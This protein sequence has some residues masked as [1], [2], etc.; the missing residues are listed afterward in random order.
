MKEIVDNILKNKEWIFSGIGVLLVIAF[1]KLLQRFFK[2]RDAHVEPGQYQATQVGATAYQ[3]GRDIII[4]R[5]QVG[6]VRSVRVRVHRAF[7][8]DDPNVVWHYFINVVNT[9]D[10]S[11]VEITHV[12][13][14]GSRRIDIMQPQRTLPRLLRPAQSWETWVRVMD[15]PNNPDPFRNFRVRLSTDEVFES[16]ER[17]NVQGAGFVPG[18]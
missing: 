16:E 5:P 17:P 15:I 18:P 7:F 6:T 3:A 10:T 1:V 13:Y 11:D 14:E 12:W 2:R 8:I 4:G 9:S